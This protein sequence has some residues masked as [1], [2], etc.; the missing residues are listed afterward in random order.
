MDINK[1]N[2]RITIQ[3]YVSVQDDEGFEEKKWIDIAKIWAS[4]NNLWG[5]EFYAA[6]T[7]NLEKTVEFTIRYNKDI[8]NIDTKTHRILFNNRNFNITFI[9]NI[10]YENKYLKIKAL[11]EE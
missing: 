7:V 5:K 6:K 4:V 8:E 1:L 9:D 3:K 2:K 11:E 10:R